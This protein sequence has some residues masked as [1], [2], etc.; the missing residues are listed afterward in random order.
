MNDIKH[1]GYLIIR[2]DDKEPRILPFIVQIYC[3]SSK[4]NRHNQWKQNQKLF[5]IACRAGVAKLVD[6]SDSKSDWGN[7][8]SV[9]VR[10]SVPL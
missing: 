8:V 5:I 2:T 6:A 3:P 7:S 10:P 4:E 1:V 9:R